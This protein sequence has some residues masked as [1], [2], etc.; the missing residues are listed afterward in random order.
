MSL[1]PNDDILQDFLVEAGE[2][3]ESL[4]EQLVEL[5]QSPE[6]KDLLNAVF[7]SFHT[8]KG[9][10]SFLNL[11]HL[12]EICHRAED[13]FNV[14]RNGERVA[15]GD[16]MDTV[17]Q[18]LDVVNAMFGEIHGGEEPSPADPGLLK[19]L[20]GYAVPDTGEA[21]APAVEASAGEAPADDVEAEFEA[22][23]DA[24]Q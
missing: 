16:L 13:V 2:L 6:D 22:M 20:E 15:D 17:L 3:L 8:I 19:A 9:G 18:V 23:L 12:V 5:E 11:T 14:L 1:D 10:A 4:N 24:A 21:P 7:R